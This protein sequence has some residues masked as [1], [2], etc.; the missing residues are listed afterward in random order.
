[1]SLDTE[2]FRTLMQ[3]VLA[4]DPAAAERLCRDYQ[5]HILRV[6]RR[7]LTPRLRSRFDSLD[8]VQDVWSSFFAQPPR[9]HDFEDPAALVAY[10]ERM[11]QFKVGEVHRQAGTLK[12]DIHR[13]QP[14]EAP[15]GWPDERLRA[16]QPTPSQIV[17]AEDEWQRM[18]RGRSPQHQ[19][20][21]HLLRQGLSHREIAE[22][23][24]TTEKTI[25]RLVRNL[26][27]KGPDA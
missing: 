21:L 14:L 8:Y 24:K 13:E 3:R 12:N 7:R 22:L 27:P 15:G 25:Q 1:M 19:R 17:G 6:V 26:F 16:N 10:L 23:L 11:A 2:N 5:S 18:L 9:D 20:I 4:G